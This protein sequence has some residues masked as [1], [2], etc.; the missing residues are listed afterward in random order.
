MINKEIKTQIRSQTAGYIAG[1]LGLVAGLAWGDA[2]KALIE[3]LFP[4]AKSGIS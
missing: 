4:F 1:A 3:D 2:I